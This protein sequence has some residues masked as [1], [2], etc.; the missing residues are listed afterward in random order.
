MNIATIPDS[1]L[2]FEDL[3]VPLRIGQATY[4]PTEAS[5]K[6]FAY[7]LEDES[8][9]ILGDGSDRRAHPALLSNYL[10]W[11][12]GFYIQDRTASG[13][14]NQLFGRFPALI[15][16]PY[17]HTRT[18]A[19]FFRALRLDE[20]VHA[21][22][23]V[24]QKYEKRNKDYIVIQAS[25]CNAEGEKLAE[26]SH[27]C[28]IRSRAPLG[29]DRPVAKTADATS[30]GDDASKNT[31]VDEALKGKSPTQFDVR[32]TLANARLYSLPHESFH[33]HDSLAEK[34]GFPRAVP[35]GLMSFGYLIKL[36]TQYFG[37][38]WAN[39][40]GGIDVAFTNM[41]FRDDLLTVG[42][43]VIAAESLSD[44]TV[45]VT[46]AIHVDNQNGRRVAAGEASGVLPSAAF[47]DAH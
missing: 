29:N 20:P 31:R 34:V 46:L 35:Q 26:Y 17:L 15:E 11:P 45:K 27:T 38:E 43:E 41:L 30:S 36:C 7:A 39:T 2:T 9:W 21:V 40:S 47:A 18:R 24:V 37:P 6:K 19:I 22:A 12:Q 8:G 10:W 16:R 23:D 4:I 25:Y 5:T 3:E 28:M 33:T 32:V 1:E 42:G 14:F 44:S 13:H